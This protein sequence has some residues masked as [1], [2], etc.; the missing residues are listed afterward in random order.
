M[1][2]QNAYRFFD[3][4]ELRSS[5]K[6]RMKEQKFVL[7]PEWEMAVPIRKLTA[8][9]VADATSMATGVDI[10]TG[11]IQVNEWKK[12]IYLILFSVEGMER[13]DFSVLEN[14]PAGVIHKLLEE[15]LLYSGF[16]SE[17]NVLDSFEEEKKN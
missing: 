12:N 8:G 7:I 2:E 17:V 1:L 14:E 9:H 6:D 5:Q 15:I 10:D 16:S 13:K 3:I 4:K 11:R